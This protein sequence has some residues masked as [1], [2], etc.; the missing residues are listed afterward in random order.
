[1]TRVT[2]WGFC[3]APYRGEILPYQLK[4]ISGVVILRNVFVFAFGISLFN[5]TSLWKRL[6]S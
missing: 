4:L 1:M 5:I 6:L 2:T 3:G